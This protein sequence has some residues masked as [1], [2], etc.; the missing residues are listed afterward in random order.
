MIRYFL[1]FEILFAGLF[2]NA[3]TPA[4]PAELVPK[5]ESL[6]QTQSRCT[7]AVTLKETIGAATVDIFQR[8]SERAKELNCKSILIR[9][10][11]PGGHLHSTRLITEHVIASP[12]PFLCLISPAGGHAG[13]A[14][15]IILQ[16]CHVSGGL[17]ATN[18]GAATPVMGGGQD[19]PD[20]LK[21]KI[22]ND[23][24][25]WVQGMAA[26]RGRS[27]EFS[28]KIITEGLAVTSEQAVKMKAMDFA[29][30]TEEEFLTK[31]QGL[32][33]LT[34]D[35]KVMAVEVGPVQEFALD[36]R[37]KILQFVS[38]PEWAYLIF[39]GALLLLYAEFSNPGLFL[40][41]VT[42]AILLVLALVSFNKLDANMGALALMVLGLAFWVAELFINSKGILG[43]AGTISFMLGSF[44]LF[45]REKTGLA[46]PLQL[47][48]TA[49]FVFGGLSAALTY[50]AAKSLNRPKHDFDE[51]MKSAKPE[52][53]EVAEDG[54]SGMVKVVGEIWKFESIDFI[55]LTDEVDIIKRTNLKVILKKKT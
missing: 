18:V 19:I 55:K 31:S 4:K 2:L 11:T 33:V 35:K 22:L 12:I 39:L 45:D 21:N 54:K 26:L 41:G 27:Q 43:I 52:I 50:M 15:A 38:E 53:I 24:V 5:E 36:I 32:N 48:L 51:Q 23:T 28:K 49:G 42:G 6:F 30:T 46:I 3:Q 20:D 10:N 25:S 8:V 7:L 40:P 29:T 13:S 1:A 37:Y 9:I 17:T 16:A 47:I 34:L 14:G 44:L